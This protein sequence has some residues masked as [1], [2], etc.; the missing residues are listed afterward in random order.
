MEIGLPR[1]PEVIGDRT[2]HVR[3]EPTSD[4]DAFRVVSG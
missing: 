2:L 3:L 4:P 1:L